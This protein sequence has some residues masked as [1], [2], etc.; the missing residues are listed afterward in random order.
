MKP[1]EKG[2]SP[3]WF[4]VFRKLRCHKHLQTHKQPPDKT[5]LSVSGRLCIGK[6]DLTS[7]FTIPLVLSFSE[8][9]LVRFLNLWAHWEF[10]QEKADSVMML[11]PKPEC[12]GLFRVLCNVKWPDGHPTL[13]NERKN[14]TR[15]LP[16]RFSCVA[17]VES[18]YHYS[19]AHKQL[20][21]HV[22]A[23]TSW[24]GLSMAM[25]RYQPSSGRPWFPWSCFLWLGV[26]L[27]LK[28]IEFQP[29]QRFL[30]RCVLDIL[31]RGFLIH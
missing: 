9:C 29:I 3:D 19:D 27:S 11:L 7:L 30:E 26:S 28:F 20:V 15:H 14:K 21:W 4:V 10:T 17:Q 25:W 12:V 16:D 31:D 13:S 18:D 24:T 5:C 6:V 2:L 8:A 23:K 1:N 22:P